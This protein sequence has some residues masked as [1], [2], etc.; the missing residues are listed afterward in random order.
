MGR[1]GPVRIVHLGLGGFARAHQAW[2]TAHAPDADGWGIAGFTG[3]SP[4]VARRLEPQDGLF[5]LVTRGD[6][7]AAYEVVASLSEVHAAD[8]QETWLELL[9]RGEVA[10]VTVTVT[11]AGYC[12]SAAGGLD[13]ARADVARDLAALQADSRASVGTAPGRLVAGLLARRAAGGGGLTIV[14]CDNLPH[15]G[16]V[17]AGVVRELADR[18]DL[19]LGEWI[20]AQ[21]SFASTMVD[22]IT[23]GTEP[24]DVEIVAQVTGWRD[25][26]PVVTEPYSEWVISGTFPGGRPSWE[27]AS[28]LLV[29][30]VEPFET[31]KLWLLNG[32]HSILALAGDLR[33]H[34]TVADA[35]ADAEC[36]AW[37]EQWWDEAQ[38]HL[39][40]SMSAVDDYRAAL[41]GRFA[42]PG[43]EH[44]L[45]QIA[46]D[47][48]QKVPVRFLP[49]LRAERAAGRMPLGAAR[50]I[51][52]WVAHLRGRGT[53]IAD[54]DGERWIGLAG[55]AGGV[56][57]VLAA[58]GDDLGDDDDLA[59]AVDELTVELLR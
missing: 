39:T 11:E 56:R 25:E 33:G 54:A 42:N 28:A 12:R 27:A 44:R 20:D 1:P 45:T 19:S 38:P 55:G 30:D 48:S 16:A 29:D 24:A 34:R 18:V 50:A 51:G 49:V 35:V 7:D 53:P 4:D 14:P 21:V 32:A 57:R 23:P 36:H 2:Y 6:A 22:R 37:V 3:R 59:D 17:V 8:D 10:V 26:A 5:T 9:S 41:L 47:S 58:L 31:R 52:A 46:T 43:I 13:L 15:N 40:L